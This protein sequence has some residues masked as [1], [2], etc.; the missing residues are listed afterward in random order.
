MIDITWSA[1]LRSRAGWSTLNHD[2]L[3]A[4][5]SSIYNGMA[6]EQIEGNITFPRPAAGYAS[7]LSS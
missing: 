5:A 3:Q 4:L 2:R 1:F 6:P 7:T